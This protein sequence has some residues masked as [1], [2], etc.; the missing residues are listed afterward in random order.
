MSHAIK[1][2]TSDI[3]GAQK[4]QKD[5]LLCWLFA[6]LVFQPLPTGNIKTCIRA[7]VLAPKNLTRTVTST[8]ARHMQI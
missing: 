6:A 4:H 3:N 8:E 1:T 5:N 7:N 2:I